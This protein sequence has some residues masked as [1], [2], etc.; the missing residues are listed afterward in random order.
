M[1]INWKLKEVE[2]GWTLE[3]SIR[4]D[5]PQLSIEDLDTIS[6]WLRNTQAHF[7]DAP[8]T[9]A[10]NGASATLVENVKMLR[11]RKPPVARKIASEPV[12]PLNGKPKPAAVET[13]EV[14]ISHTDKIIQYLFGSAGASAHRVAAETGVSYGTASAL[15]SQMVKSGKARLA[16]EESYKGRDLKTYALVDSGIE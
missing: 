13:Q 11:K 5:H 16:G 4:F 10:E 1:D 2:S 7:L 6:T 15:L 14:R 8:E 3:M 12:K 9:K